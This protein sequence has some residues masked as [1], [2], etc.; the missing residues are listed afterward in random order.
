MKIFKKAQNF[1]NVLWRRNLRIPSGFCGFL[2]AEYLAHDY[3][4]INYW[5]TAILNIQNNDRVLEVGFGPGIAIQDMARRAPNGYIAGIDYSNIMVARAMIR[6]FSSMVKGRVNLQFASVCSNLPVFPTKFDK[7]VAI[8]NVMYWP[9]PVTALKRLKKL[10]RKD[11]TI[12]LILQR[13]E[14]RI[15]SGSCN[16]EMQ[17][18]IN[19]LNEAGYSNINIILNPIVER[20]GFGKTII[21]TGILIQAI[22][23][24]TYQQPIESNDSCQTLQQENL[25]QVS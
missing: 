17:K 16:E 4:E 10:L 9:Q 24:I 1:W 15:R 20:K 22:N 25:A 19:Y 6:N 13:S 3:F 14:G 23:A 5:A 8:N 21:N 12:S 7:I 11:G 2:M 18:Y